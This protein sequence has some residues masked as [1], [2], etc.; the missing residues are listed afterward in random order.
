MTIACSPRDPDHQQR[1][2][3]RQRVRRVFGAVLLMGCHRAEVICQDNP[4]SPPRR[5]R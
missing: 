4:A 1:S 2:C 5:N 3:M